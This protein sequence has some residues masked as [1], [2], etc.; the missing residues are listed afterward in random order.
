MVYKNN[1]GRS[2]GVPKAGKNPDKG[3]PE[4][5]G[6]KPPGVYGLYDMAG[7]SWEWVYDW[8]SKN[9]EKCGAECAGVD[10]KGPCGG[11][12]NC[13]KN[14]RRVVRGGSWY[15]EAERATTYHRRSHVPDNKPFHH[16]GFR[17]AASVKEA[18]RL[19]R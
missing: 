17:C 8:Y 15:W 19:T 16:F 7:N 5:V 18:A 12:E 1:K 11:L 14:R 10:P 6:S 4:P 3:R 2:C 9:W 13:H